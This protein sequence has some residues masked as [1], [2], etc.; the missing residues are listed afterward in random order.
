MKQ[1]KGMTF[2]QLSKWKNWT[3]K[4]LKYMMDQGAITDFELEIND[5]KS[6]RIEVENSRINQRRTVL[7]W[8]DSASMFTVTHGLI[9]TLDKGLFFHVTDETE[10]FYAPQAQ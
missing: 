2:A 3:D 5:L 4:K 1:P 8:I 10:N 6:V 7:A 9:Y